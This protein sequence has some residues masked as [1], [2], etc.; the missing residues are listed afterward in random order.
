MKK[1]MNQIMTEVEQREFIHHF[2]LF[3]VSLIALQ[4]IVYW[5]FGTIEDPLQYAVISMIKGILAALIYI[6]AT[7]LSIL[8]IEITALKKQLSTSQQQN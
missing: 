8:S 5:A 7:M 4:G 3:I 1:I 2:P 6:T